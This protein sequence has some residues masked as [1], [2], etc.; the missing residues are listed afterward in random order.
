MKKYLICLVLI[1]VLLFSGCFAKQSTKQNSIEQE[2]FSILETKSEVLP[3]PTPIDLNEDPMNIVNSIIYDPEIVF[4]EDYN[5][6][7]ANNGSG[8]LGFEELTSGNDGN[9]AEFLAHNDNAKISFAKTLDEYEKKPQNTNQAI[10]IRF[11]SS[12][13]ANLKFVFNGESEK[14]VE[15]RTNGQPTFINPNVGQKYYDYINRHYEVF[16]DLYH[17]VE[18]YEVIENDNEVE[19]LSDFCLIENG[20]HYILMTIDDYS[21]IRFTLWKEGEAENAALYSYRYWIDGVDDHLADEYINQTPEVWFAFEKGESLK[22]GAYW[23]IDYEVL[24]R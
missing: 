10:L 9:S 5:E 7:L 6:I 3:L 23:I 12:S 8:F 16:F 18:D 19:R 15:F 17:I 22:I 14:T 11:M 13:P 21:Y 1:A 24:R 4:W 20:W 2:V